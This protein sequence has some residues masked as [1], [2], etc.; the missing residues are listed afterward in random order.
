MTKR[1]ALALAALAAVAAAPAFAGEIVGKVKYA[2][3]AP[4]PAP[5]SITKDQAV[6]GK[7]PQ[8]ESSLLV[9]ADK[10]VKN[11]V[12][13]ITDPKDG[14]KMAASATNPKIDQNGCK[15]VPR[16]Q[17]VPAGQTIDIVNDDGILHNIHSWPKNNVPFNKAQPKFKKVM[18][19]KFDKPDVVKIS[20]DVHS[21]M[22]G[23][24]IVAGHPYFAL[25]DDAGN[26]KIADVPAG[27]YTLEYWHEKLGT[28]TKQVTVPAT[29]S[30]QADFVYAAK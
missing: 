28:Q 10:S 18:T 16:V 26:F 13:S 19:E 22:Q 2:G 17:I 6:C 21:W 5:I 9:A 3:N 11:V 15:F 12:V 7:T 4:T 27:T 30:V 23:Y 20:C 14:K 8:V 29:G 25:S 1:T 24:I